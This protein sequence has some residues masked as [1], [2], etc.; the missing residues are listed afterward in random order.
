MVRLGK[1]YGNLMVDLR[2]TNHKLRVRSAR[3]LRQLCGLD[4]AAARQCL[5]DAG[6]EL[7]AAILMARRGLSRDAAK[8]LLGLV[9]ARVTPPSRRPRQCQRD[10]GVTQRSRIVASY[11]VSGR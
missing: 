8:A 9:E 1:C 3:I 11:L 6:G 7:K 5:A 10:A 4:E 2:A